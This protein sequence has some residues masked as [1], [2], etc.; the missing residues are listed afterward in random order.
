MKKTIVREGFVSGVVTSNARD[1]Q[2]QE[3][4]PTT[5]RVRTALRAGAWNARDY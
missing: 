4:K 2:A 1:A 5:L 3:P